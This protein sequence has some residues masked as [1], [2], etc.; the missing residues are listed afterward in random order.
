M[1]IFQEIKGHNSEMPSAF[2][3]VIELEQDIVVIN[4]LIKFGKDSIKTVGLRSSG[5]HFVTELLTD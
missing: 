2:Y 5:Q 1:A 3:L 4:I